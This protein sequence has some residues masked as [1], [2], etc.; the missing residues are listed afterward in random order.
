M[1]SLVVPF[2]LPSVTSVAVGPLNTRLLA[3]PPPTIKVLEPGIAGIDIGRLMYVSRS[4]N[5]DLYL[6]IFISVCTAMDLLLLQTE[7]HLSRAKNSLSEKFAHSSVQISFFAAA[8]VFATS[9]L[10]CFLKRG[11]KW[12]G[13]RA[14]TRIRSRAKE[15]ER[16]RA[17][18]L[19]RERE[20]AQ[21]RERKRKK[22]VGRAG[23]CSFLLCLAFSTQR[24]M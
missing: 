1:V 21:K 11:E 19:Q 9:F 17:G 13:V 6:Y 2:T 3:D 16:E 12:D 8:P 10:G 23:G 14:R 22:G 18:E 20:R 7:N 4:T 15:E 24:K 5:A